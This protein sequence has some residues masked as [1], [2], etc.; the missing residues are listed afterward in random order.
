[1]PLSKKKIVELQL[2]RKI[3][4]FFKTAVF[5]PFDFPAVVIVNPYKNNIPAP[6]IYWLSCP[7][8]NYKVDRLESESNLPA[9]LQNLLAQDSDFKAKMEKAHKK[10]AEKRRNL[11]AQ[12]ELEEAKA[13][14]E[15][16]Y[17]TLLYSGVGGIKEQKGIK[18]LHTHLAHFLADRS[19]PVGKIV[20]EK[21]A[22]PD[23]CSICQER[24]DEFASSCN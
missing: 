21:I 14:S 1:M 15:D 23:E 10:Y 7:Y 8:L 11:L 19:N 5:C 24:I 16:L 12:K 20:F 6:T 3:N 22:W 4:N 18:C 2:D 17:Q 9:E 13:L